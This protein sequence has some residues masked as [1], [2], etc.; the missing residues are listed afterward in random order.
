MSAPKL[1]HLDDA[2]NAHMVDVS[3]NHDERI[4]ADPERFDIFRDDLYSGKILRSGFDRDGRHSHMAFGVGPHLCP[5]A[6]ISHQEAVIGSQILQGTLRN[7]RI[8]TE[9]MRKD[10]DGESLAPIGLGAIRELAA[11]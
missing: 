1:T 10:I 7:V 11:Y 6:W 9:R 5:G 2:G 4:F 3:A 8:E